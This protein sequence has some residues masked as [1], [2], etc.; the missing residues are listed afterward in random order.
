MKRNRIPEI[1]PDSTYH[2]ILV[3]QFGIDKA[4]QILFEAKY[5]LLGTSMDYQRVKKK[6]EAK[7]KEQ[8]ARGEKRRRKP[9]EAKNDPLEPS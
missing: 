1:D 9:P 3:K 6:L 2:A 7:L 8:K 4:R 5:P